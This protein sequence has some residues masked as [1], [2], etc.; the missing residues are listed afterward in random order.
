MPVWLKS[1]YLSRFP[2][3]EHTLSLYAP[4]A[5]LWPGVNMIGRL[6]VQSQ[7]IS[8]MSLPSLPEIRYSLALRQDGTVVFWGVPDSS[9]QI[10]T[11]ANSTEI[12]NI[13]A[14]S[15]GSGAHS[16]ALRKDGLIVARGSTKCGALNVPE[17]LVH[18]KA[19]SAGGLHNLALKDNGSVIAWGD[20]CERGWLVKQGQAIIP[21]IISPM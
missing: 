8:R 3:E 21:K 4:T 1:R 15:A 13:V 6:F 14:I 20:A 16:L 12:S 10:S 9:R 18:V 17:D 2:Q 5:L 19:I 11:L 7:I